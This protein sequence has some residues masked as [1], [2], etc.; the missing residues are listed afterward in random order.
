MIHCNYLNVYIHT[1][2]YIMCIHTCTY[3]CTHVTHTSMNNFVHLSASTTIRKSRMHNAFFSSTGRIASLL[4]CKKRDQKIE[5]VEIKLFQLPL[6]DII[7]KKKIFG[8]TA[9]GITNFL[10]WSCQRRRVVGGRGVRG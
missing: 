2:T 3:M 5:N 4:Q 9:R 6:D 10:A 7:Y 1:C 8:H